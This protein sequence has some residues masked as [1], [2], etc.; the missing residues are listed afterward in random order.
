MGTSSE[1]HIRIDGA[2]ASDRLSNFQLQLADIDGNGID[3]LTVTA[4][5][6]DY[7]SRNASG[8]LYIIYDSILDNYTGTGNTIDLSDSSTYNLRLS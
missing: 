7:N 6:T 8:S 1:W 3:D 4:T 2:A 5:G